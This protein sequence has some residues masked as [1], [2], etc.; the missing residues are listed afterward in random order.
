MVTNYQTIRELYCSEKFTGDSRIRT[1]RA[2]FSLRQKRIAKMMVNG[3]ASSMI[4]FW[5]YYTQFYL[6]YNRSE[7]DAQGDDVNGGNKFKKQFK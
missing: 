4:I 7:L 3:G 6:S 1:C 2:N 5:V